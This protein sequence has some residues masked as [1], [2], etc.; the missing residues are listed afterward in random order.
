RARVELQITHHHRVVATLAAVDSADIHIH[1]RT[2]HIASVTMT[3]PETQEMA[4]A[5]SNIVNVQ[6]K[7]Q[8]QSATRRDF[9]MLAVF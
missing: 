9:G 7:A 4:L 5:L 6:L 3:A 2:G 1:T 8:P